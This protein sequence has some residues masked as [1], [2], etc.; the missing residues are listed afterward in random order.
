MAQ[1]RREGRSPK[2]FSNDLAL[3][4]SKLEFLDQVATPNSSRRAFGS[5]PLRF[6]QGSIE[7]SNL[8]ESEGNSE[9]LKV[10]ENARSDPRPSSI[11]E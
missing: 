7:G 8:S 11:G 5:D 3:L 9:H 10:P 2:F 6:G 4:T 1:K